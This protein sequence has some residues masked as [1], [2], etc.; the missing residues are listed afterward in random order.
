MKTPLV[1]HGFMEA[2][3]KLLDLAAFFDRVERHGQAED[4]R[5]VALQQC[6]TRLL[7]P[8]KTGGRVRAI[9]EALSDQ[10]R[11]PVDAAGMQGAYGAPATREA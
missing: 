7:E 10:T 5:V 3:A 4:F 2:R 8:K 9:L 1:D 11:E 6:L